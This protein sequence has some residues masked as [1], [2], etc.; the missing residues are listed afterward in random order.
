VGVLPGVTRRHVL[1]CCAEL[2]IPCA[3]RKLAIDEIRRADEIFV[4]SAVRGVCAITRLDGHAR[5]SPVGPVTQKLAQAY[6]TR[7]TRATITASRHGS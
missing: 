3:E 1:A 5:G 4:T 6:A 2:A 7:M